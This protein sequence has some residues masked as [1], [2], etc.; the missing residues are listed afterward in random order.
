VLTGRGESGPRL[1]GVLP[2]VWNVGPRNPSFV[3]RDAA[4]ATVRER[5][6]SAAATVLQALHGLGGVG[7]TQLAIEYAHRYAGGYDLVWWVNAEQPSLIGDQYAALAGELGLV[8]PHA[9]TVSAVSAVRGYLRGRGRWLLVLDNAESPRDIRDWLPAGPGHVLITSRNPGWGEL[10]A[11]VEVDVLPR[12]DSMALLRTA[13]PGLAETDA[14]RLAA[15][16]GDLPLALAQAGG[17]LAETGMP[18]AQYLDLLT[19]RAGEL[20]DQSPPDAHPH[21]LAA[22]IRL[23]TD[24]LVE[25]DPAALALVR[26]GAFL[27]TEPIPAEVLIGLDVP[28]SGGPPPELEALAVTVGSPVAAH[29]S[30]GRVGRYGL[31]R[32][33]DGLQLHRLTQAVLRDQLDADHAAAYRAYAQALLV[34]ADPGDERDPATWPSWARFLPHLLATDP[35]SS[36][37]L[38]LRDLARRATVYLADRGDSQPARELA[39]HL[40]LAW[41]ENL[42]PDDPHTLWIGSLL[43]R[44]LSDFGPLSRAVDLGE[45]TLARFQRSLGADHPYTLQA[46]HWLA[47]SLH[48]AGAVQQA[49]QLNRDTLARRRRVLGEDHLDCERTANNLARDLSAL[50][51]V[52]AARQLQEDT[53]AYRQRM[54]GDDHPVTINATKSLGVTLRALGQVEAAKQLHEASLARGRRVLGEDH[55]WTMDC[56]KELASDLHAL[57]DFETARRLNEDA[58]TWVRCVLGENN[59]FIIEGANNLVAD[60]RALGE[61][62]PARRLSEETL[63][64]A[65]CVLGDAHPLTQRAAGNLAAIRQESGEP[66]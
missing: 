21:S 15:A 51:E 40:H 55:P 60:L 10:A 39:E 20:L 66:A 3:G 32:V 41:H 6:R 23:S 64:R 43:G 12:A 7:K 50:G 42:G 49:S 22:A 27:S 16:L 17:F 52:E 56:Q 18:A 36:P 53:V 63:I 44:L 45:D 37:N 2:A 1:P 19:T 5:L 31:G 47:R 38:G 13:R 26:V 14:D 30:L 48:N 54:F 4:L 24:R 57:G 34:A 46:A 61:H 29:R 33:D 58:L 9:D 25:V 59:K 8:G 28:P 65:R 35:A 62:E 11:R